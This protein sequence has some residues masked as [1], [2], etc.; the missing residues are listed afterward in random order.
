MS[1]T[2]KTAQVG[3]MSGK[4]IKVRWEGGEAGEA[5]VSKERARRRKEERKKEGMGKKMVSVG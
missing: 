2:G 1:D 5:E 3:G 4:M